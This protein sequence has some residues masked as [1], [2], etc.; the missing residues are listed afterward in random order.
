[1][2]AVA[3]NTAWRVQRKNGGMAKEG[4]STIHIEA[5]CYESI[6]KD[7]A[8]NIAILL[9]KMAINP[10]KM[11]FKYNGGADGTGLSFIL[12]KMSAK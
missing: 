3:Q 5:N 1:M 6:K 11:S 10:S 2:K 12:L 8:Y 7:Y 9:K 4:T